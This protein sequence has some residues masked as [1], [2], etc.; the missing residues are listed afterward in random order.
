VNKVI[1]LLLC[2]GLMGCTQY[3]PA[4]V[5]TDNVVECENDFGVR[6]H[7]SICGPNEGKPLTIYMTV[8]RSA[9]MHEWVEN[10]NKTYGTRERCEK[11]AR[12]NERCIAF[13][14]YLPYD[15]ERND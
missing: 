15:W 9:D 10:S 5:D 1:G 2:L 13:L 7:G 3:N 14:G 8:V 6:I 12:S 11:V 4:N